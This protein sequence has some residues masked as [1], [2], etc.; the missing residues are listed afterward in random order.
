MTTQFLEVPDRQT[1]RQ[2]H[3]VLLIGRRQD[4]SLFPVLIDETG[5]L[6]TASGD[7]NDYSLM[8]DVYRSVPDR[9]DLNQVHAT[10]LIGRDADGVLLPVAVDENGRVIT[11]GGGG[12]STGGRFDLQNAPTDRANLPDNEPE[13]SNTAIPWFRSFRDGTESIIWDNEAGEWILPS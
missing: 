12:G 7:G 8:D 4:N 5:V 9:L 13:P 2:V 1:L 10:L 3:G 6:Q 11:D